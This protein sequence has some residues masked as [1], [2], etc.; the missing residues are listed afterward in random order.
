MKIYLLPY[1]FD[2][3]FGNWRRKDLNSDIV[4]SYIWQDIRNKQYCTSHH[5][6]SFESFNTAKTASDE[7]LKQ[8]GY[9]LIEEDEMERFEKLK[10]LL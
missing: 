7:L 1:R 9:Y 6:L 2:I 8:T 5:V 10:V 4:C 3:D